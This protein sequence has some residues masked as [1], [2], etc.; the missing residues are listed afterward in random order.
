MKV[1]SINEKNKELEQEQEQRSKE[2]MLEVLD[3]MKEL[4]ENGQIKEFVAASMDEMG[5]VQ[6]HANIKDLA[7][8]VGLFE[9]GKILL[10]EQQQMM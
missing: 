2:D 9:I 10:I 8:G 1:V 6:I 4:V 3:Y 5:G 7:G